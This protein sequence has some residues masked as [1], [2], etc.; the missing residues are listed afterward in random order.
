MALSALRSS[1][2]AASGAKHLAPAFG[3][4]AQSA[5]A[6]PSVL[7][8]LCSTERTATVTIEEA[9]AMP[10]FAH[11]FSNEALSIMAANGQAFAV[12]ERLVR[13]IMAVDGITWED[14]QPKM[15]A[16]SESNH[17]GM[18]MVT[19]PYKIGIVTGVVAAFST[20]PLCFNEQVALWFNE[21]FVTTEVPPIEDRETWLEIGAWTWNWME[22]PLGQLSFF[23]LCLQYTR[24]QMQNVGFKPYTDSVR[25]RRADRLCAKF[26]DYNKHIVK[27]FAN[28]QALLR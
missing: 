3:A 9:K 21:E 8:R 16:I 18:F 14:A 24:S 11:E 22:P 10:R 12:R 28:S 15:D 13:E 26:P 27:G 19:L 1:F 5:A 20:F 4:F 17:T 7:A 23:L 2:R 25:S 6:P